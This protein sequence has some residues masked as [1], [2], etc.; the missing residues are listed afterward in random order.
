[1][2]EGAISDEMHLVGDPHINKLHLKGVSLAHGVIEEAVPDLE[3]AIKYVEEFEPAHRNS[4][5][6]DK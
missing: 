6:E 4:P 3:Y 2:N 1:M 5:Y